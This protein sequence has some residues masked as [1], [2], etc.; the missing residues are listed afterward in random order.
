MKLT[1]SFTQGLADM[2][3]YETCEE[4]QIGMLA[5][6]IGIPSYIDLANENISCKNVRAEIAT[7]LRLWAKV[8]ESSEAS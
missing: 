4:T 2:C 5:A 6:L 7:F 1:V 8:I 3:W